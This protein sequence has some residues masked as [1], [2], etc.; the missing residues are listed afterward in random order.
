MRLPGSGGTDHSNM[1]LHLIVV[2]PNRNSGVA[3]SQ[4]DDPTERE[5]ARFPLA[6]RTRTQG[7]AVVVVPRVTRWRSRVAR[8]QDVGAQQAIAVK[9]SHETAARH[10]SVAC[11]LRSS[12]LLDR[13]SVP[14]RP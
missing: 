12:Q 7:H 3:L 9:E 10:P 4:V 2:E 11:K 5:G 13:P 6:E 8:S 14:P 1:S